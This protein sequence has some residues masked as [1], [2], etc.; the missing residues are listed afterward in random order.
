MNDIFFKKNKTTSEIIVPDFKDWCIGNSLSYVFIYMIYTEKIGQLYFDI[1]D[2]NIFYTIV[3]SPILYFLYQDLFFYVMHRIAHI[4]FLY[5]RIHYVHHQYR[6]PT[7]WGGR[8]SHIVDSNLENIAFVLPAVII[9]MYDDIWKA[10]LIFTFFWGNFLHDSTNKIGLRYL[11]D[12]IDH[13]LH[14]KYGQKNSNYAYYFNHWDK[15]F[16]TYKKI[17]VDT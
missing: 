12:S 9:P 6:R 17:N 16:G 5:N 13:C 3:I 4:P 14:H 1:N 15:W 7:S 11:N 2:H 8:I 10:C